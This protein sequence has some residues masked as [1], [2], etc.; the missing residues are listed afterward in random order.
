MA[1]LVPHRAPSGPAQ[2]L[3][4]AAQG[5][6][7]LFAEAVDLL[8]GLGSGKAQVKRVDACAGVLID[9]LQ[10]T[11][12][13]SDQAAL[14]AWGRLPFADVPRAVEDTA[15]GKRVPSRLRC[16]LLHLL[17]QTAVLVQGLGPAS[18]LDPAVGLGPV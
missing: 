14:A 12:G 17:Q 1:G 8:H 7:D 9:G 3:L 15:D 4:A 13:R 2:A 16:A 11:L 10:D 5:R 6:D 18:V